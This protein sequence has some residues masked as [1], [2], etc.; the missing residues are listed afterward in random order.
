MTQAIGRDELAALRAWSEV[1]LDAV[2]KATG[3][4]FQYMR[5]REALDSILIAIDARP[6]AD[7]SLQP[8]GIRTGLRLVADNSRGD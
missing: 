4:W 6:T 8:T 7:G 1:R 5:L 3:E 2:E